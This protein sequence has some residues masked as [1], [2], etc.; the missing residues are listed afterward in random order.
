MRSVRTTKSLAPTLPDGAEA[1]LAT[2][3]PD[4]PDEDADADDDY[5]HSRDHSHRCSSSSD[6]PQ[7]V[8]A[9]QTINPPPPAH[10]AGSLPA[11]RAVATSRANS[12]TSV[13]DHE[14]KPEGTV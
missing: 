13:V 12:A 5:D 1:M 10:I 2:L 8:V 11:Q 6:R 4:L 9:E 3:V 7:F 14:R